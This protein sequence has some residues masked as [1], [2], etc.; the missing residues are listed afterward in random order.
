MIY[1]AHFD[2]RQPIDAAKTTREAAQQV[3]EDMAVRY[4]GDPPC[5]WQHLAQYGYPT[6]WAYVQ[7][8]AN[9]GRD[10]HG[11]VQEIEVTE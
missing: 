8:H 11:L 10:H 4:H 1:L 2:S 3:I 6:T 7:V 5:E 9:G